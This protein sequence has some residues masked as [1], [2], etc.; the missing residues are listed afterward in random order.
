MKAL[1]GSFNKE[2]AQVGTFSGHCEASRR[3]GCQLY[4]VS[5]QQALQL[6]LLPLEEEDPEQKLPQGEV[7][8]QD[9]GEVRD[10]AMQWS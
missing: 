3:P 6:A 9:R 10:A 4:L 8:P 1:V 2:R 5:A 7:R